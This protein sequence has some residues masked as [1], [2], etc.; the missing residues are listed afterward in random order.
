MADL[1]I[2]TVKSQ[3]NAVAF[4]PSSGPHYLKLRVLHLSVQYHTVIHIALVLIRQ[5]PFETLR[6]HNLPQHLLVFLINKLIYVAPHTLFQRIFSIEHITGKGIRVLLFSQG[7]SHTRIQIKIAYL[8]VVNGQRMQK[9]HMA[10]LVLG[11]LKLLGRIIQKESLV[12]QLPVLSYDL[13]IAHH[14]ADVS[15]SR[16]DTVLHAYAVPFLFQL[17]DTGAKLFLILLHNGRSNHIKTVGLHL[18]L[19]LIA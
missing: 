19:R 11:L 2:H 8:I 9:L 3:N 4:R 6:S 15:L 12:K 17:T 16:A 14:I 18:L 13:D 7:H 10:A 5:L 1:L